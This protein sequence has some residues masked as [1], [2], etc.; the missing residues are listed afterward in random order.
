MKKR[1]CPH[2]KDKLRMMTGVR[3]VLLG[4]SREQCFDLDSV[5]G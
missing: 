2:A 4:R 3:A 5:L 1:G